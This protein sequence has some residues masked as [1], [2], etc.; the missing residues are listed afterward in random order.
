MASP[1]RMRLWPLPSPSSHVRTCVFNN[2]NSR[3]PISQASDISCPPYNSYTILIV[4]DVLHR[5]P[6]ICTYTYMGILF[7]S[8]PIS[9][10]EYLHI[11][12]TCACAVSPE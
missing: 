5:L 3:M 6:N 4:P 7:T 10:S 12:F 1:P 2:S 11:K 8:V 9:T